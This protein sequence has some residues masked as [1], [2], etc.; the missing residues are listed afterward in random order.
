MIEKTEFLHLPPHASK[1]WNASFYQ[2]YLYVL[3][4]AWSGKAACHL[5]ARGPVVAREPPSFWHSMYSTNKTRL[6]WRSYYDE[7]MG[8]KVTTPVPVGMSGYSKG[9]VQVWQ[10]PV[11]Q[12]TRWKEQ[13]GQNTAAPVPIRKSVSPST[14]CKAHFQC[15][16][17]SR[18]PTQRG[19][20]FHLL[21]T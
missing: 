15:P 13:G 8:M 7:G 14:A 16:P 9:T 21:T 4:P 2:R 20:L 5:P 10:I 18:S 1:L 17:L 12:A 19:L 11:S 3:F 6:T